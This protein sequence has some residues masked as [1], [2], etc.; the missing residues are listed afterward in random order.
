MLHFLFLIWFNSY[1]SYSYS[2]SFLMVI[3]NSSETKLPWADVTFLLYAVLLSSLLFARSIL[4]TT[5]PCCAQQVHIF[6]LNLPD[7]EQKLVAHE[8]P[9]EHLLLPSCFHRC[10]MEIN[11][12]NKYEIYP[13]WKTIYYTA[14]A[15]PIGITD[16][17]RDDKW[18]L[19]T[20]K[21]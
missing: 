11:N 13:T 9:C 6:T 1:I 19:P 4:Q 20:Y 3:M 2:V 14:W 16:L 18:C 5:R 21:S 8:L 7:W 10:T 15:Q 17:P 12:S